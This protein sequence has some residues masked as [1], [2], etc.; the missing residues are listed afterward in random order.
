MSTDT[1]YDVDKERYLISVVIPTMWMA[2]EI[3]K[4]IEFL[5]KSKF[6]KE[7]IIINNNRQATPDQSKIYISNKIKV[8]TPY[9]NVFVGEGW[10]IGVRNSTGSIVCLLNDDVYFVS[11]DAFRAVIQFKFDKCSII[12]LGPYNILKEITP[13]T[14]TS[15][16]IFPVPY[17]D[18]GW[19][20]IMFFK[21]EDYI[22]IPPSLKVAYTDNFLFDMMSYKTGRSPYSIRHKVIGKL[23]VTS[24]VLFDKLNF[25]DINKDALATY[26]CIK[27]IIE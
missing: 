1:K 25:D 27:S 16:E 6:V 3:Y 17:K 7:I 14:D 15:T 11:E 10:N 21:R 12:G 26:E 24:S 2:N 8:V 5:S 23:S 20:V 9:D 13:D 4:S 22:Y 19:G 18:Y